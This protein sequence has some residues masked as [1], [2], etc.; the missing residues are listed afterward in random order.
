MLAQ[1]HLPLLAAS[2]AAMSDDKQR[3]LAAIVDGPSC[4]PESIRA[5]QAKAGKV[6]HEG[7]LP[8]PYPSECPV[9][10]TDSRLF[11]LLPNTRRSRHIGL[12]TRD[13]ALVE[14]SFR[15]RQ[16][17]VPALQIA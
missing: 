4:M 16:P 5:S 11:H 6:T 8:T 3:E 12:S 10:F 2:K 14:K 7:I 13:T 17:N 1:L 9:Y 15:E